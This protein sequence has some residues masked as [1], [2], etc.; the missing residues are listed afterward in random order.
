MKE[1]EERGTE[2]KSASN[3]VLVIW[4]KFESFVKIVGVFICCCPEYVQA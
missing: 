4:K 2:E 3:N 1:I